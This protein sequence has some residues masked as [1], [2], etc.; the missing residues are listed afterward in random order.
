M[1]YNAA[2]QKFTRINEAVTRR[3]LLAGRFLA[4]LCEC[5]DEGIR[6]F[7]DGPNAFVKQFVVPGQHIKSVSQAPVG[8]A[9]SREIVMVFDLVVAVQM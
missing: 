5:L 2:A 4:G 7:N 3:T 8:G 6:R 1:P 9:K